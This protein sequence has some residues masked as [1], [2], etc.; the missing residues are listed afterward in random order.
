MFRL[1]VLAGS[2]LAGSGRA[3][4]VCG[5]VVVVWGFL[6]PGCVRLLRMRLQRTDL[7][8]EASEAQMELEMLCRLPY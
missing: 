7:T 8:H 4:P 5:L 2:C 6:G 1:L 3:W